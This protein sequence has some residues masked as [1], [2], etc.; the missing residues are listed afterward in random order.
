MFLRA[1]SDPLVKEEDSM[2][3]VL[4]YYQSVRGPLFAPYVTGIVR[5]AARDYFNTAVTFERLKTQG[6]EG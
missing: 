6:V 3:T 5:I 4:L 1:T 2:N